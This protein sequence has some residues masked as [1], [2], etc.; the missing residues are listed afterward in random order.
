MR[1]EFIECETREQAEQVAPWAAEI[2]EAEGGYMAFES[3]D[4]AAAW[5]NQE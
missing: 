5:G 4:D 2:V 1:K 3:V